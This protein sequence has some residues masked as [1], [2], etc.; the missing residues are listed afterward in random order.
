MKLTQKQFLKG[1]REFEIVEDTVYVSIK[2]LFKQEKLTVSL[3]TLDPEPVESGSQLAF[4][5]RYKGHPVLTLLLNNPNTEQF[6]IF[7]DTL[8]KNISGENNSPTDTDGETPES[9]RDEALTRN[10]YEEP[11]WLTESNNKQ[12]PEPFEPVNAI[13]LESDIKM[14]KTYL[15]GNEYKDLFDALEKL[16]NQPD[17]EADYLKVLDIFNEL[18]FGQGAVLTYAPYLKELLS[19]SLSSK[20]F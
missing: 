15:D 14:L 10:V 17:N 5:D 6:S 20:E 2:S 16:K 1:S 7:I 13:R 12:E 9:V 11:A 8:K 4:Y 3:S 19:N 18:G